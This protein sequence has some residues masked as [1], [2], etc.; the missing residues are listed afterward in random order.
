MIPHLL[1]FFNVF[2]PKCAKANIKIKTSKPK[3]FGCF[4]KFYL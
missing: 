4:S 3:K 2:Y 1:L